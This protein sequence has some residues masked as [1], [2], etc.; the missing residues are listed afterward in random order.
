MMEEM[1]SN[2][3]TTAISG[4]PASLSAFLFIAL[5]AVVYDR[6]RL[7][8]ELSKREEKVEQI[9]EA[10]HQGNLT[11]SEALNNLKIVLIELKAKI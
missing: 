2:L 7:L 6:N 4:G 5:F 1:I 11:L 3:V 8:K 9:V 10:Y